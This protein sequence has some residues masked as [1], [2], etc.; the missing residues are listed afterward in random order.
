MRMLLVNTVGTPHALEQS[1]MATTGIVDHRLMDDVW[2]EL[3]DRYG[4]QQLAFNQQMSKIQAFPA[5][6]APKIAEQ[7]YE[8]SDLCFVTSSLIPLCPYLCV[9]NLR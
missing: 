5:V 2:R 9:L 8:F 6:K 4:S 7:L 1:R 3:I